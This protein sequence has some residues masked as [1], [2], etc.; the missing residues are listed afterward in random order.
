MRRCGGRRIWAPARP[1]EHSRPHAA[2]LLVGGRLYAAGVTGKLYCL[3][4]RTGKLRRYHDGP[5][6]LA[7][8]DQKTG[9]VVWTRQGFKSSHASP[10]LIRSELAGYCIAT[11]AFS[12]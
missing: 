9:A 10:F 6:I 1:A 11:A 5:G 3:Y 2:A 4:S 7:A 8:L 12:G